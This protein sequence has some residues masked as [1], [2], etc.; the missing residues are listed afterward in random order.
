[1]CN[2][3]LCQTWPCI[4][5]NPAFSIES[6]LSA[7]RL[8]LGNVCAIK[9]R[10]DHQSQAFDVKGCWKCSLILVISSACLALAGNSRDWLQ[11]TNYNFRC[12]APA[13]GAS[14]FHSTTAYASSLNSHTNKLQIYKKAIFKDRNI[15]LFMMIKL[16]L[17][18]HNC[19]RIS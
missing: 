19:H 2:K 10:N 5:F 6:D 15:F 7:S 9:I 14:F 8:M 18:N 17:N 13:V 1:M 11:V 12:R 4:S 16:D 3:L